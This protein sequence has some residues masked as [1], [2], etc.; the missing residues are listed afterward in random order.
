M[1]HW[2]AQTESNIIKQCVDQ[3]KHCLMEKLQ[4]HYY[5]NK[6]HNLDRFT[7]RHFNLHKKHNHTCS[8]PLHWTQRCKNL[9]VTLIP[10]LF[11]LFVMLFLPFVQIAW[12]RLHG[13]SGFMIWDLDLD[14]FINN[15]EW[16]AQG[17]FPLINGMKAEWNNP[18]VDPCDVI[19]PSGTPNNVPDFGCDSMFLYIYI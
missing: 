11:T 3:T 12:T 2:L 15:P 10:Y 7:D 19:C 9:R 4:C 8:Y 6:N 14:D 18:T 1:K 17:R 13:F 16:C 5:F